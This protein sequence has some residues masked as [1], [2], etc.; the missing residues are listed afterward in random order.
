VFTQAIG[1]TRLRAYSL[2]RQRLLVDLLAGHGIAARGGTTDRGAFVVVRNAQA[3]AWAKALDARGIVTDARGEW[4]RLCPD[5]LSTA[6]EL[7]TAAHRLGEIAGAV[8]A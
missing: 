1:V 5:V 3:S 4:L 8:A 7:E 2:E 6:A